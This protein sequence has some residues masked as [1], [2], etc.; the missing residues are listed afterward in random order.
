M[1]AT[2]ALL[3]SWLLSSEAAALV[4][5]GWLRIDYCLMWT[6]EG[7]FCQVTGRITL[8]DGRQKDATSEAYDFP[9]KLPHRET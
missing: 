5:A 3:C 8:A 7:R 1:A 2:P 6:G 4:P 9:I